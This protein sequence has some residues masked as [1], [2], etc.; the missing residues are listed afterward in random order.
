MGLF[1]LRD[2]APAVR[3]ETPRYGVLL[4]DDEILN[5]TSLAGLLEDDYRVVVASSANDALALLA[6]PVQ[7]AGIQ[8]IVSDQRMPGMSGVELLAHTR[9]LCPDAKRLLLTGYTDIDAVVG[10]INEAA[11]W[12]Y[13]RKPVDSQELRLTL[14]RACEA[15]QL[16]RDNHGLARELQRTLEK[17]R[18]LDADK[19][20]FLHYLAHEMNTPLNWLSAAQVIDRATLGEETRDM[21]GFVDQGQERL[22]GLIGAVLRYFQAAGL[23]LRP[24]REQV[25][26]SVLLGR[27]V[28]EA[29]RAHGEQ[30]M[31]KLEQ[32]AT[33]VLESDAGLLAELLGHLL[34]NAQSHALRGGGHPQVRI[35]A[36]LEEANLSITVHNSGDSLDEAARAALLRP[37]FFCGSAHGNDG[38]GLSL[39]TAR[40]LALAL[41]GELEAPAAAE[42]V[43]LRLRLPLKPPPALP[44]RAAE[45]RAEA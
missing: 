19:T 21:L 13:L 20:A 8:V 3:T 42:G 1:D 24:Q 37:F 32:P 31:L 18:L 7:A 12:K 14:A 11:V 33:L 40:A 29:Q 4:V 43:S 6:D 5:L 28:R 25:D 44:G 45:P 2:R 17:M 10:A 34:E 41:G 39:A 38:Y 26:L 9:K 22:R 36:G 30:L 35:R 23:E 16:E 15:W 27:L